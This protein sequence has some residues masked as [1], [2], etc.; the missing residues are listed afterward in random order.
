MT[1]KECLEIMLRCIQYL[2]KDPTI[3]SD[4]YTSEFYDYKRNG[5]KITGLEKTKA[6]IEGLHA[7]C[8]GALKELSKMGKDKYEE[9]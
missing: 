1:D 6:F 3:R 2:V 8:E 9:K 5:G 4:D 7:Y